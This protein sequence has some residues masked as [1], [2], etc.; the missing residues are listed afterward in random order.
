MVSVS[1]C[2]SRSGCPESVK[3]TND[4][5]MPRE[6]L[7]LIAQLLELSHLDLGQIGPCA[8]EDRHTLVASALG[9]F[10]LPRAKGRKMLWEVTHHDGLVPWGIPAGWSSP[11]PCRIFFAKPSMTCI[12]HLSSATL[13]AMDQGGQG[14]KRRLVKTHLIRRD[15]NSLEK[16]L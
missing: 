12:E 2:Q 1:R 7:T 16:F 4:P 8:K 10:E 14:G 13:G 15:L 3:T 9:E 5:T 11:N 6:A